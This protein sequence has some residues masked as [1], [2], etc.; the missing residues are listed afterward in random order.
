MG[1]ILI[2]EDDASMHA[3]LEGIIHDELPD[4]K[5]ETLETEYEFRLSWLPW[6]DLGKKV[7]PDVVVIDV[8]LRW[9]NPSVDQPPRPPEVIEGGFMRAGLRCLELI[10]Q[11]PALANTRLIFLTSLTKKNL[12]ALGANLDG[13]LLMHKDNIDQLVG[14]IRPVLGTLRP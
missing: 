9:T 4:W 8:M 2:L 14:Q 12:D 3:L 7:R 11:R 6:F 5:V 13:V 10:R 1:Q